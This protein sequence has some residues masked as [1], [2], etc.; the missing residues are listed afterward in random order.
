MR[1][2]DWLAYGRRG[3]RGNV[4]MLFALVVAALIVCIAGAVDFAFWLRARSI[5]RTSIDAAVLR[6]ARELQT[7]PSDSAAAILAA[8]RFYR[9]SSVQRLALSNDTIRFEVVD[10]GSGIAARGGVAVVTPFAGP[11]GLPPVPLL[12]LSGGPDDTKGVV[13]IG[14]N[15]RQS[16]EIA[17]VVDVSR[18]MTGGLIDM[19]KAPLKAFVDELV[20]PAAGPYRARAAIVPFADGVAPGT[21]MG[22]VTDAVPVRAYF[23]LAAGTRM[24]MLASD[25][26][27]ERDGSA[28]TSDAAPAGSGLIAR[29]YSPTGR[30]GATSSVTPLT[31]DSTVLRAGVDALV[32]GSGNGAAGHI[33]AAW[34]WYLM[35]PSW[36]AVLGPSAEPAP[37]TGL[38][39]PPGRATSLRKIVLMIG[40][41]A[42]DTQTCNA[43]AAPVIAFTA[44]VDR[45]SPG[46]ATNAGSCL[47]PRGASDSQSDVMCAA[48][49]ASG[50]WIFALSLASPAAAP[51]QR[52]VSSADSFYEAAGPLGIQLALQD[53]A[54]KITATYLS[55]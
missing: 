42:F 38:T 41:A 13:T 10:G 51:L 23:D 18:A 27:G 55:R 4:A 17:I 25:C 19:L 20:W 3:D 1:W 26:V 49:R 14:Q 44:M 7:N 37:Y 43:S 22:N 30:C 6:G 52:C 40:A 48:M 15:A 2:R 12:A 21:L 5:V 35:S 54:L 11:M 47:S 31:P 9:E 28:A 8:G 33:G 32:A 29:L 46:S 53:I 24:R 39:E 16:L 50:L 34:G 45:N 36:A